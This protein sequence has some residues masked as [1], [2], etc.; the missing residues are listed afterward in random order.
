MPRAVR[1]TCCSSCI[2]DFPHKEM[3]TVGKSGDFRSPDTIGYYTMY[4]KKCTKKYPEDYVKVIEEHAPPK[5]PKVAKATKAKAKNPK[6]KAT[7]A[8]AKTPKIKDE[9]TDKK[10]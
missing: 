10:D 5:K 3:Y 7:K 2:V 8:K 4:C 6:A 1:M 9:K